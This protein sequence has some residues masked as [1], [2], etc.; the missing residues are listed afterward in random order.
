MQLMTWPRYWLFLLHPGLVMAAW[1]I[2]GSRMMF[3]PPDLTCDKIPLDASAKTSKSSNLPVRFHHSVITSFRYFRWNR[4]P[5]QI[6]YIVPVWGAVMY[7]YTKC[8]RINP[9]SSFS[10]F[11][12]F[13][14]CLAVLAFSRD[15]FHIPFPW[16]PEPFLRFGV[17]AFSRRIPQHHCGRDTKISYAQYYEGS[18]EAWGSSGERTFPKIEILTVSSCPGN[19]SRTAETRKLCMDGVT[20][21]I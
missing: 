3:H 19:H 20:G 2:C 16:G 11:S 15:S 8:L 6:E 7:T 10:S 21:L 5:R 18:L 12:P 13:S 17:F 14:C 1:E 4:N 9:F